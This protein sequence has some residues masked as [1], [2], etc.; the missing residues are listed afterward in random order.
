[1]VHVINVFRMHGLG[2]AG[3]R[4]M[5]WVAAAMMVAGCTGVSQQSKAP[6]PTA[7]QNANAAPQAGY[8]TYLDML[9]Y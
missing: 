1:M 2:R 3:G 6:F 8:R 9:H 5:L 4:V 7:V